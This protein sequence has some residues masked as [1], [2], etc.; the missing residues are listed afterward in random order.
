MQFADKIIWITG[1]SSGIGAALAKALSKR[2][3]MLMLSSRNKEQLELVRQQC[4]HPNEV[5]LFPLDVTDFKAIE[6]VADDIVNQF[7]MI[8]ILINNAG[9][10]QRS[11]VA[12]TLL[13]VD[14][15]I[16]D[17][18]YFGNIALTKA[19]LPGMLIR[20]SG[21]VVVISSVMGKVGTPVRSAYA[22]SKHA[23]HGFYDSLRAEVEKD[24]VAITVICPGYVQTQVSVNALTGD[25]STFQKMSDGNSKGL[26]ADAFAEKALRVIAARKKEAYIGGKEL[27]AIYVRRFF[28]S[29]WFWIVQ[30]IKVT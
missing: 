30:R 19:M 21:Q 29:L 4:A 6:R 22:A 7:G 2:G 23:L 3:A 20:K 27:L 11:L 24:G 8:D 13:E 9:I 10:S 14:Q 28:P 12:D 17:V 5:F 25:G 18:N 15:K 16:M 1:A 26:T